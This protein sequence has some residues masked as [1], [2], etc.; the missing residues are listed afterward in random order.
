MAGTRKSNNAHVRFL[1][2]ELL[3]GPLSSQTP[4]VDGYSTAEMYINLQP[5]P[6]RVLNTSSISPTTFFNITNYTNQQHPTLT[7]NNTRTLHYRGTVCPLSITLPPHHDA[8][9][10]LPRAGLLREH[11][12]HLVLLFLPPRLR[13]L[14][15]VFRYQRPE[16]SPVRS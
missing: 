16:K 7:I 12:P 2:G 10:F 15:R 5:C 1:T 6:G 11:I 9:R 8:V 14:R 13:R 3:S 4:S